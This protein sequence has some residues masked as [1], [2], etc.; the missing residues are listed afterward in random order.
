MAPLSHL[1]PPFPPSLITAK[2]MNAPS[3]E[4]AVST[5]ETLKASCQH[6][7]LAILPSVLL[8][9]KHELQVTEKEPPNHGVLVRV[10]EGVHNQALLGVG[11]FRGRSCMYHAH[12]SPFY[13]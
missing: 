13:R 12:L 8:A 10:K 5:G 4:P 6:K 7:G 2:H 11:V 3:E 1:S 9:E